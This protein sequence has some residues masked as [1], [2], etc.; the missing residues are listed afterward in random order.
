LTVKS[1]RGGIYTYIAHKRE[2]GKEQALLEHLE[3][4]AK[5]ASNFAK[6][7]N[8]EQYAYLI[9]ILHDL[10]KYSDAF[11]NRILNNGK[12]CDHSTAGAKITYEM[13]PFGVICSYCIAGHHSGLQNYGS[14]F[15]EAHEG[16]LFSRLSSSNHIP[17]YSDYKTEL[18]IKENSNIGNPIILKPLNRGGY[19]VSFLTRM[20]YSALVDA[21][22]LDTEEFMSSGSVDRSVT[23]NFEGCLDQI[24]HVTSRFVADSIVNTKRKEILYN[25]IEK[26][27]SDKGIFSLTVPTGGGKTLS[28]MAF[29]INHLIKHKMDRIIYVIPYT[30]I[31][32]QN[33]MVFKKIFGEGMVLEHHSNFD[34]DYNENGAQ[35]KDHQ[36]YLASEN[37]DVPII[38]TTNVQFFESLYGNKSSKCRKLHN[39]AN[40]VIIF[41]E[42]QMF[43][44]EYLTPCVMGIVELVA[45]CNSTAILCSATQPALIEQFPQGI[46]CTEIQED[47]EG[48]YQAFVRAE[49]VQRNRMD[50]EEIA[51]EMNTMNQCLC[52]VN[53]RKHALTIYDYLS[54]E[55]KYHLSTLMCPNHRKEVVKEIKRRLTGGL[56]CKVVSTRLIEAGVD[57]DFPRV[58]R[59]LAGVDSIVQAAGRCNREG[60]LKNENGETIKGEVHIFE[61]ESEFSKRQPHSFL[62]PIEVTKMM[63]NQFEDI[64]IPDAISA[65][66][67]TLYTYAGSEGLDI[68]NIYKRLD[69]DIKKMRKED[70]LEYDFRSIAEDFKL[71]QDNSISIIIPFN[72]KVK[73]MI[74]D[75]K[76]IEFP[77]KLLRSLQQYTVSIYESEYDN[78][79]GSG[80]ILIVREGINVLS[81]MDD[82]T[83]ETGLNINNERGVGIYI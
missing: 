72:D 4:T 59:M 22:Y 26:S 80:K 63:M 79:R 34:F 41:D 71:I 37:W 3:N 67:K 10:G 62:R 16:T 33:A 32:E 21:D 11:Q 75:L 27:E 46:T 8:N 49:I 14:K 42:V 24:N 13:K 65:Y 69:I 9:G 78:L 64:S 30:S 66:F 53:T 45:N 57:V 55:G 28:S 19:S 12:K 39:M 56:P 2:D 18:D 29:A 17:D 61:A 38:V 54:G 5:N 68:K 15:D 76:Y 47:I 60:Q 6:S 58:Y 20:L 43:P 48:L 23:Y 74:E 1:F 36:L 40:S 44:E 50:S 52:I 25:C 51:A 70:D 83:V 82:Y 31:I 35:I 77:R 7:F 73:K 81:S